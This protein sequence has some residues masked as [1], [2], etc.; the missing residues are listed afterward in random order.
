MNW[1]DNCINC[2]FFDDCKSTKSE[3]E[4]SKF[5]NKEM[6]KKLKNLN[7]NEN[8]NYRNS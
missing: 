2:P 4:C 1:R 6:Y 3:E 8:N 7:K 5:L